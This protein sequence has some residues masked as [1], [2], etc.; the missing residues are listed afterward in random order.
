MSRTQTFIDNCLSVLEEPE[1]NSLIEKALQEY[2]SNPQA[3]IDDL[4]EITI[5]DYLLHESKDI[6]IY[7]IRF[8][9]QMGYPLHN[10]GMTVVS[11][12]LQG[13]ETNRLFREENDGRLT[14]LEEKKSGWPETFIMPA[15]MLHSPY[16]HENQ[17]MRAFH[18]HLGDFYGME[19][20]LW[21]EK[22]GEKFPYSDEKFVELA[23]YPDGYKIAI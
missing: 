8:E 21:D 1:R 7:H 3:V 10:H 22:T 18:V 5:E 12:V 11:G 13:T 16:N 4:P 17:P 15:D 2:L 9:P 19:H 23:T 6:S 20:Y 14:F